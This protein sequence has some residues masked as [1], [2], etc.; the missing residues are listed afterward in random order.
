MINEVSMK[1]LGSTALADTDVALPGN[2]S[3]PNN[4][5]YAIYLNMKEYKQKLIIPVVDEING[6]IVV[7]HWHNWHNRTKDL[8]QG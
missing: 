2:P 3:F 1:D 6:F 5:P 7:S 4:I 8:K